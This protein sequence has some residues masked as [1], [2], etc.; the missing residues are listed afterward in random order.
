MVCSTRLIFFA[1]VLLLS[2]FVTHSATFTV[3]FENDDIDEIIDGNCAS[4]QGRCTLRAAIQEANANQEDDIIELK[5]LSVIAEYDVDIDN[6]LTP[7]LVPIPDNNS[8]TGDLDI[9]NPYYKEDDPSTHYSITIIGLGADKSIIQGAGVRSLGDEVYVN[10]TGTDRIFDVRPGATLILEH[11]TVENGRT[12]HIRHPNGAIL[13]SEG[14]GVRNEEGTLVL[15]NVKITNNQAA[16]FGSGIYSL[17]GN[18]EITDSEIFRNHENIDK[19]WLDRFEN[20]TGVGTGI[21]INGGKAVIRN[22][23]IWDNPQQVQDGPTGFAPHLSS[24]TPIGTMPSYNR[25]PQGGRVAIA[26]GGIY[27]FGDLTIENSAIIGNRAMLD[28]GGIYHGVGELIIRNTTISGNVADR[29]GG[30]IFVMRTYVGEPRPS[31]EIPINILHSTVI[32]NY[33]I[34]YDYTI[35]GLNTEFN[36]L[37]ASTATGLVGEGLPV[38]GGHDVMLNGDASTDINLSAANSILGNCLFYE[39]ELTSAGS[40]ISQFNSCNLDAAQSDLINTDPMLNPINYNFSNLPSYK[41]MVGS[42]AFDNASDWGCSFVSTDQRG[43]V[44]PLT[45]CE[46]GSYEHVTL[47]V[48]NQVYIV[49]KDMPLTQELMTNFSEYADFNFEVITAPTKGKFSFYLESDLAYQNGLFSYVADAAATGQDSFT[50]RAT[51]IETGEVSEN[52]GTITLILEEPPIAG[53]AVQEEIIAEVVNKAT[54]A[55]ISPITVTTS[56]ELGVAVTDVDYTY[57]LGVFFFSVSEV[58]VVNAGDTVLRVTMRFPDNAVE[59][60]SDA[61]VRKYDR[62]GRWRSLS[63][64]SATESYANINFTW[65]PTTPGLRVPYITLWLRDNDDFDNNRTLGIINDPIAIGVPKGSKNANLASWNNN[66]V[67]QKLESPK[68]GGGASVA[69]PLIACLI[70]LIA[71]MRRREDY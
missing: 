1:L 20:I 52:V 6:L 40:N 39:G 57:P 65:H 51:E 8:L 35:E 68:L 24:D 37:S 69:I 19:D 54:G 31:E 42:P 30:G 12:D 38:L 64:F 4:A 25:Y 33:A 27:S 21:A 32:N 53:P 41:P 13:E 55:V 15:R 29:N 28:G 59:F 7:E 22:T 17:M 60:P 63:S 16:G 58:P 48:S 44:R 56:D 43:Y 70:F 71:V 47:K 14:G 67:N 26:G 9:T 11:L 62:F 66:Q 5:S 18:L 10:S 34:G 2:P 36:A 50:F 45:N 23:L 3:L 61:V 46:I 49:R